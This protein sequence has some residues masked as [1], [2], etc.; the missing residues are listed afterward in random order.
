MNSYQGIDT[1]PDCFHAAIADGFTYHSLFYGT[2]RL[3]GENIEGWNLLLSKGNRHYS[4]YGRTVQEAFA[5]ARNR[6]IGAVWTEVL[7]P[8]AQL[9]SSQGRYSNL[10]KRKQKLDFSTEDL[11]SILAGAN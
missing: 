1:F 6:E 10:R 8:E 5:A 3:D 4:G 2:I 7:H 11:L 9:L